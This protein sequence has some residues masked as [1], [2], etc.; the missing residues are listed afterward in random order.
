MCVSVWQ[1][2][3]KMKC[4]V[5]LSVSGESTGE[6]IDHQKERHLCV[7]FR[8]SSDCWIFDRMEGKELGSCQ[9][10]A[11]FCHVNT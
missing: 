6:E 1:L 10:K 4:N 11:T 5:R 9:K 2:G 3:G 7:C 8:L